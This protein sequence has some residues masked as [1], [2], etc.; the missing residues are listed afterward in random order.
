M[1]YYCSQCHAVIYDRSKRTC[2]VCGAPL[3]E[4]SFLSP[5]EIE[6]MSRQADENEEAQMRNS[7]RQEG[8]SNGVATAKSPDPPG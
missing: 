4:G 2:A 8:K 6:S 5:G 1:K 3:E 7:V